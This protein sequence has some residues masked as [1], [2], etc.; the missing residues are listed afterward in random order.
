MFDVYLGKGFI[1]G[2]VIL[3]KGVIILVVV[4]VDIGCGMNVLCIVLMVVDLFE[5]LVE[6]CQVIE[7][8]VLYG[9]I[10]GCCKCDKGVW[11]N[12]FVNVDVKWVE[13]EVGYQWLM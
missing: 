9:C 12:L 1:I 2:S 3:I 5:N 6:L 13:F 4:G 8:V 7:M 10:I 11:E